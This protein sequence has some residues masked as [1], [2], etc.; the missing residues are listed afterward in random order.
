MTYGG[1]GNKIIFGKGTKLIVETSKFVIISIICLEFIVF[2][3]VP[4]EA[5]F[6]HKLTSCQMSMLIQMAMSQDAY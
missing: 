4:D 6:L 3:I 2:E 5:V 1:G